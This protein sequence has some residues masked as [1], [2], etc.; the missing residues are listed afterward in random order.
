MRERNAEMTQTSN[1]VDYRVASRND[2]TG[3]L[4]VL[5]EVAPE[6]PVSIDA[7]DSQHPIRGII[8]ECHESGKSWVAVDADG[9]VVGCVLAK[10]DIHDVQAISLRY[11]GV[12]GNSRRRRIFATLME[13]MKA[14]GAPLTASV[15]HGNQSAM[16]DLLVKMGFTKVGS[17]PKETELR[18]T[19]PVVEATKS[20]D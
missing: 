14:S 16:A 20:A 18:W 11:I 5:A 2:E 17:D 6:I 9:K 1:T 8:R 12:S 10:K 4:D 19:P 7:S 3:I 13:K 15:L